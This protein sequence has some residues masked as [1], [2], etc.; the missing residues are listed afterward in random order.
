MKS[1]YTGIF[2]HKLSN[3]TI[4]SVQ[5]VDTAGNGND[6]DI[7]TYTQRNIQPPAESLPDQHQYK[8]VAGQP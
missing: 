4:I 6:V 1:S 3:G 2:A 7:D 5:C 8:D